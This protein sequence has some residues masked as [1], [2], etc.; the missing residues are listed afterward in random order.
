M[1]RLA[2][3]FML[4]LLVGT[5]ALGLTSLSYA[6]DHSE[7]IQ[8]GLDQFGI[9]PAEAGQQNSGDTVVARDPHADNA[10]SSGQLPINTGGGNDTLFGQDFVVTQSPF[11]H[12]ADQGQNA[13]IGGNGPSEDIFSGPAGGNDTLQGGPNDF[14]PS[15]DCSPFSCTPPGGNPFDQPGWVGGPNSQVFTI[16]PPGFTG[17]PGGPN[18]DTHDIIFPTQQT[19]FRN[20]Q[21]GNVGFNDTLVVLSNNINGGQPLVQ[22][23][24]NTQQQ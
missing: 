1:K 22:A 3:F 17:F 15:P 21:G 14:F 20:D 19:I 11:E 16:F 24:N 8:R 6:D 18:V 4:S 10:P 23:N 9:K 13:I 5:Q 7:A 12:F 2:S